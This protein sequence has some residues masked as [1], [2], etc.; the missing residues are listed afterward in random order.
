MS[1]DEKKPDNNDAEQP[2]AQHLF[3]LRNRLLNSL[4][5]IFVIFCG[6]FYF[7]NDIYDFVSAPLQ[8]F[9]PENSSMIATEVASPFL[10]PFKLTLFAS[11]VISVP[12][13]LYQLWRFIAPALYR[14][15]KHLA[16]PLLLSSVLLFY[17]G[18]VFAYF[19]VFPLVFG[20]FTSV[21]P[22]SVTVMTDI[23]HYLD[24]VLK[25]F[26]A[27]GLAFEIPVATVMLISAGIVSAESLAN[28]RPYIIIS[29]FIIG[30]LL[31]PPDVISQLLLALPMW[32]LFEVGVFFGRILTK[33]EAE[34]KTM[35]VDTTGDE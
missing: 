11:L 24:F 17:T 30:M 6:L 14:R 7:A 19:A 28:K 34:D 18:M 26:F 22:E 31:T 12:F 15:E 13:L 16:V 25:L 29:C 3:E 9:L 23:G 4:I 21:G 10:A 33:G 27:F 2:L 20:F 35:D 8:K 32:I 1:T 5:F